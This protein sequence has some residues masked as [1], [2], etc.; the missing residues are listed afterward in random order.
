MT[1]ILR[2]FGIST[3]APDELGFGGPGLTVSKEEL[4]RVF[5]GFRDSVAS[6]LDTLTVNSLS[7]VDSSALLVAS[8]WRW[9]ELMI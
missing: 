1:R 6:S 7:F 8:S 4:L 2:V 9:P 5:R 3:A